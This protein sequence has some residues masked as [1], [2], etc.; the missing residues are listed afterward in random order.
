MF[1]NSVLIINS[2]VTLRMY[3]QISLKV[4]RCPEHKGLQMKH[5]QRTLLKKSVHNELMFS[6]F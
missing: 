3:P 4:Q 5:K 6:A 2:F 1:R